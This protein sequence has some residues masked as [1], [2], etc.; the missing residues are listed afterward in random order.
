MSEAFTSG[1]SGA[2][3]PQ[4]GGFDLERARAI[5]ERAAF[6]RHLGIELVALERGL[7]ETR[8]AIRPEHLQQDAF[9]HAGVQ[10]TLADHTA[11]GAAGTV[12]P[13]GFIVLTAE[14]K[15]NLLRPAVGAWLRCVGRVIKP[16]RSLIVAEAEVYAPREPDRE[17]LVAKLMSTLAVVPE[18]K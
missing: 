18:P 5:F 7:V 15:I 10:T 2:A 11:G 14:L 4:A 1:A 13:P 12:A 16:G 17:V 3:E 8:L 6:V 9:I